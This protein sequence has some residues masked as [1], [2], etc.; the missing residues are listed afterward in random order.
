MNCI[1]PASNLVKW[2][3]LSPVKISAAALFNSTLPHQATFIRRDLFFQFGFYN[4]QFK[5]ASDWLFF[6][7]VILQHN[8]S[9]SH[10]D[11]TISNFMLDGISSNPKSKNLAREEQLRI[12]EEKYPHFLPDYIELFRLQNQLSDWQSSKE[13]R[14]FILL[15]KMGIIGLG[16]FYLRINRLFHRKFDNIFL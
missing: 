12:L 3:M 8:V 15:Q 2:P 14:A 11:G 9:Y 7:E 6:L 4:V 1:D 13:F 10:F 5:I 16:M